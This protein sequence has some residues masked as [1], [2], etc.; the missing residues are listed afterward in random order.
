MGIEK[1]EY[2]KDFWNYLEVFGFLLYAIS[3]V[4]DFMLDRPEDSLRILWTFTCL[5]ALIKTIYLI[6]VFQQLNF[7]VTMITTVL[8][9]IVFFLVMFSM[10]LLTFAACFHLVGVDIACYGRMNEFVAHLIGVLRC[11]MGDFA[12]I[13]MALGFDLLQDPEAV[14]ESERFRYSQTI[15]L[16]TWGLWVLS[17]FFTFMIFMN[18]IIAV[19]G[20]SFSKVLE[21][22]TAHDYQQRS[23][24]IYELEAHFS[25]K[26]LENPTYFP[27]ILIVRTK[28]QSNQVKNNWQSCIKIL[29]AFIKQQN[30]KAQDALF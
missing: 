23:I 20:D 17:I 7:L 27:Q 28:K 5:L 3:T 11:A 8:Q 12:M 25:A 1:F 14:V 4:E 2:L 19:I 21:F 13:D 10:Y 29:K 15:M 26:S 16:F 24:M 30:Q 9:D 18:F 22:K 6:R